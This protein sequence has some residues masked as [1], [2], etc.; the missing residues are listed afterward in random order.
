M[1]RFLRMVSTWVTA[2]GKGF[3]CNSSRRARPKACRLPPGIEP[4]KA[5]WVVWGLVSRL[6]PIHRFGRHPRK[7]CQRVVGSRTGRDAAEAC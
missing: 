7:A 1:P 2:I 4:V 3:I 5:T 6:H